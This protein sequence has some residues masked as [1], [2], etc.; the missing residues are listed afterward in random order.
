MHA[1]LAK[2]ASDAEGIENTI[3]GGESTLQDGLGDATIELIVMAD[4]VQRAIA[5]LGPEE[6]FSTW[7][8]TTACRSYRVLAIMV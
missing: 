5:I 1:E 2:S 7:P 4:D 6:T 8:T 3:V